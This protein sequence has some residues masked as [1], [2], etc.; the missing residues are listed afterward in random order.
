MPGVFANQLGMSPVLKGCLNHC[1][2]FSSPSG[3]SGTETVAR[4]GQCSVTADRCDQAPLQMQVREGGGSD[5]AGRHVCTSNSCIQSCDQGCYFF[6][7]V[8]KT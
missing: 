7:K 3:G 2:G 8:G 5:Q 6:F 1:A 4:P